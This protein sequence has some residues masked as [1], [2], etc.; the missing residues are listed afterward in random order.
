[1]D[2]SLGRVSPIGFVTKVLKVMHALAQGNQLGGSTMMIF[3]GV[4]LLAK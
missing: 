3:Y 2:R 1:M 4:V